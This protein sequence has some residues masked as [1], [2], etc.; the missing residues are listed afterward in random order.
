MECENLANLEKLIEM[1]FQ[2]GFTI[3]LGNLDELL[4]SG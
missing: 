4:A 2:Q 1:G 3:A